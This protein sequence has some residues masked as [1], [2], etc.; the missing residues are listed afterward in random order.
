M[1]LTKESYLKL[2]STGNYTRPQ[3]AGIFGIPDWKLK[4]WIAAENL[5]AI[6]PVVTNKR[7][8]KEETKESAYWAGFLA[9]DGCVDSKGRIRFYLQISDH[10]HLNMFADFVGSNHLVS[11]DEKRNRCSLEFT[12]KEMV[13]DLKRWNIVP[14]KSITYCPPSDLKYL[15]DFLRGYFDGD[16]TICES[17]SNKNSVTA[18]LYSGIA[19]SYNFRDW[20]TD[21]I[22]LNLPAVTLKQHERENHVTITM[23]TNKSIEFLTYLYSSSTSTTRLERKYD[24]YVKTIVNKDRKTR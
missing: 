16:G 10:K 2:K 13:E 6:R 12:C 21:F 23:N 5:G 9:A 3:M 18:T 20:F 24:L 22:A 15:Q 7:A 17:F 4:K 8:F 19:C 14:S 11:L 1:E